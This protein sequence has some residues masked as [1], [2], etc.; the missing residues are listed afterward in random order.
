[1]E[2]TPY[3]S[4]KRNRRRP[5]QEQRFSS[6]LTF[7][8]RAT[9]CL[10]TFFVAYCL[11]LLGLSP[12]LWQQQE[13]SSVPTRNST[14][15]RGQALKPVLD[16]LLQKMKQVPGERMAENMAGAIK[17]KLETFRK[18][19]G[20]TDA[21]LM[22]QASEEI[23][24][25]RRRRQDVAAK[26]AAEEEAASAAH[27]AAAVGADPGR[28]SGFVVLGMHRSGTSM[29]SGL[30]VSGL[31]YNVG[32]PLIGGAFDNEKGFFE[33]VDA[34]LQNDEFMNL[35]R[36]WWSANVA[37]YDHERA[38]QDKKSGRARFSHGKKA[39]AFLNDPDN[40]PWLQKDPRMCI[41]L[42]TWLPLLNS[43]PAVVFTYRHPLEVALS[44][45]KREKMFTLDHGLRLWIIYNM[46]AVQNSR[47][48]CRVYSSNEAVLENPLT[49]V[50]RISDELTSRCGVPAPPH[51][52]TQEQVDK[53]V[54]PNLQHNKKDVERRNAQKEVIADQDGCKVYAFESE[55]TT[56]SATYEREKDLYMK[57][58][59]VYCDLKSGKAYEED[60]EWPEL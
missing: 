14:M 47:D 59:K 37:N 46:R 45:K 23:E 54:D 11:V 27:Q 44:L 50:Q 19:E 52:L 22:K 2:T 43:E 34:V 32:A 4:R 42:K 51:E 12:L 36:V 35:Q 3:S 56:G 53:F 60:Y 8:F 7:G 49:E 5:L 33:L 29:L 57:A 16:P 26:K 15:K 39:L 55:A 20:V 28:R 13:E 17:Q 10:G 58:M 41:T 9:V 1:M 38:L 18:K 24:R 25:V 6:Y 31:G 30:L 48:L 40:A 21:S